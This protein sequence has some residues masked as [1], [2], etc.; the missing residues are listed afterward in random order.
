MAVLS[1]ALLCGWPRVA[2]IIALSWRGL[3]RIGEAF[4]L[5][6][7]NEPKARFRA[8]SHQVAQVDQPQLVR[9]IEVDF[10]DLH[11]DQ[12]LWSFSGKTMRT[13]FQKLLEASRLD[14]LP[15]PYSRGLDLG[16][17]RAGGASW[18]LMMS[19]DSELTR[20]RGRWINFQTM[21]VHVQ[22]CVALQFLPNLPKPTKRIIISGVRIF[23]WMLAQ[24]DDLRRA[25]IP[26][27]VWHF[28]LKDAAVGTELNG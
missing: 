1:T 4:I 14:A 17:L 13:R 8:A 20:R 25:G 27:I 28:L 19:E 18:L 10:R 6:Q 23:P 11:P 12:R 3:T 5:L 26:E 24:A 7:I 15:C 2:G 9:L 16:S 22:E 21:E